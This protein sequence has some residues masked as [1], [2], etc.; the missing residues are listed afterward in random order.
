MSQVIAIYA[1]ESPPEAYDGSIFLAGPTPRDSQTPSWRPEALKILE[2]LPGLPEIL[3][4]FIPEAR[5]GSRQADYEN[6]IAWED[7]FLAV[8]DVIAFW[9]PRE[10]GS[11]PA[12]TTNVEFGRYEASGRIVLGFPPGATHVRYLE[13]FALANGVPVLGSLSETLAAALTMIGP[14]ARR[15]GGTRDVPLLLWRDRVFAGWLAAQEA[16]GNRLEGGRLQWVSRVGPGRRVFFW[17][18][19]ARVYVR[20]EDRVKADEVV[21][22]RPDLSLVVAY[23]RANDIADTTVVLVRE[24]RTP[25]VSSSGFVLELPGGSDPETSDPRSLAQVELAQETGLNL[26]AGRLIEHP[27]RQL[28]ATMSVHRAHLFSVELNASE[29]E[30]LIADTKIHG[31]AIDTEQ[32]YVQVRRFGELLS[33][34]EVDWSTLGEI[35]QV[36]YTGTLEDDLFG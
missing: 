9:V 25:A 17:V 1:S 5:D 6:Q 10:M 24:F 35:A 7:R 34:A 2:G 16:A 4:V 14:G 21:I 19:A 30:N 28:M 20:A 29:M 27:S 3:A 36:L 15:A 13:S 23:R 22:G 12:L 8:A 11:M 18:F 33:G 32:T 31:Q 26:D